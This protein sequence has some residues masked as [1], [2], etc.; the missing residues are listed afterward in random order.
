MDLIGD[1]LYSTYTLI[2]DLNSRSVIGWSMAPRMHSSLVCDALKMALF[3]R[4]FQKMCMF[5]VTEVAN[6]A[7]MITESYSMI[8]NSRKV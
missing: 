7:R 1:S 4:G 5:T 3:R 6:I 8:I 2:I